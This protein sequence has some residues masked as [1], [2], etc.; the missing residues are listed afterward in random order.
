MTIDHAFSIET[1]QLAVSLLGCGFNAVGLNYA[2]EEARMLKES[3][4]NGARS[5]IV[6][7]RVH[8]EI[9]RLLVQVMMVAI[10]IISIIYP[11]PPPGA[12]VMEEVWRGVLLSRIC[13]VGISVLLAVKSFLDTRESHTLR[14]WRTGGDRRQQELPYDGPDKRSNTGDE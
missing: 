9:L 13:L 10:G 2:L 3:G 12:N 4:M 6:N 7:G 1:L 14:T 11:P 5:V 8:Q